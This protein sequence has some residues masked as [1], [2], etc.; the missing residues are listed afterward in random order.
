ME[1][2]SAIERLESE[3][4][5]GQQVLQGE[6]DSGHKLEADLKLTRDQLQ[7]QI[8]KGAVHQPKSLWRYVI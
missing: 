8:Q 6:V 4:D 2:D 5:E 3:V 1:L 7:E